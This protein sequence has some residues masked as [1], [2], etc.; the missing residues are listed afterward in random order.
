MTQEILKQTPKFW[1]V[2][3]R[4]LRRKCPQCGLGRIFKGYL[5]LRDE[6]PNCHESFDGIRTDDAAPWATILVVGHL[7]APF[8]PIAVKVDIS[9]VPLTILMVVWVLILALAILP[10]MKGVFVGLN[11]RFNIRNGKVDLEN[12]VST[13]PKS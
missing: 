1:P 2:I 11:W 7:T 12:P 3:G 4:G 9:T 8:I 10:I 5:T 6:C 13:G